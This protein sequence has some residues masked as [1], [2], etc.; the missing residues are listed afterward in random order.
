MVDG[1]QHRYTGT[2]PWA[3]LNLGA[4]LLELGNISRSD[5]GEWPWTCISTERSR[6]SPAPAGA[7]GS[8]ITERLTDAGAH[9]VA[10][11]RTRSDHIGELEADGRVTFV[12]GDLTGA[13]APAELVSAA[14]RLG[15]S[16]FWS[17]TPVR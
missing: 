10:G 16:T 5:K 6:S 15:E 8:P 3:A 9:V 12:P 7:S 11:A 17:T 1:K 13:Q 4:A 14:A 2:I